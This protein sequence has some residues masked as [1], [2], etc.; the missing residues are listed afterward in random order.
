MAGKTSGRS[1]KGA[2][3]F[4]AKRVAAKPKLLSHA[5]LQIAKADGEGPCRQRLRDFEDREDTELPHLAGIG[6]DPPE[7]RGDSGDRRQ[8][9]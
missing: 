6:R 7:N 3:K 4:G 2:R 8:L 9:I 5:N 1:V